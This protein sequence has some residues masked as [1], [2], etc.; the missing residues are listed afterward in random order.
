MRDQNFIQVRSRPS[1][2]NENGY[3]SGLKLLTWRRD[4]SPAPEADDDE[5]YSHILDLLGVLSSIQG[6]SIKNANEKL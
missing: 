3:Y 1:I 4:W 2:N 5:G 6:D